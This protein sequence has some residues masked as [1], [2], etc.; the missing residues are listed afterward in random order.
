M[1]D[2]SPIFMAFG[3]WAHIFLIYSIFETNSKTTDTGATTTN[4]ALFGV[5]WFWFEALL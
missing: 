4:L 5:L 1:N 2:F 3:A